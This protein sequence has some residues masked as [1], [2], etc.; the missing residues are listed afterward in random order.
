MIPEGSE[1]GVSGQHLTLDDLFRRAGVRQP[2]GLA[3]ADPPNRET[4][5]AGTPR[6]LSY[7]EA[8]R[9]ISAFAAR[10]RGLGL[11]TDTVIGLQLPNT[12]ESVIALLGI[13]R[14][15]MIAAPLPVL[16]HRREIVSA[17]GRAGA[18]AIVT[19]SR[20]GARRQADIAMQAAAE[21]FPIRY[22]CGFGEDLPDGM[23]PFDDIFA[24][25]PG[26]AVVPPVRAGQAA[27]HV[28]AVT[29]DVTR[30]GI[31][32]VMRSHNE[33]IAAGAA[34]S[35]EARMATDRAIVSTIPLCSFAGLAVTLVPWL[36]A[37][38]ALHLHH[39]FAPE[40]FSAQCDSLD[41][42]VVAL[43]GP[44]VAP[45]YE[46]GLLRAPVKTTIALWRAPE[47]IAAA[48]AWSGDGV[49]MD[50]MAGDETGLTAA[51]RDERE[52]TIANLGSPGGV[53]R[54]GGYRFGFA[55]LEALVATA[56]PNAT[57]VSLPD[58]LTGERLA[59]SSADP[60]ALRAALEESGIS[61]LI[62]DAFRRRNGMA[63]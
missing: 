45:L 53:A 52:A 63:A 14:A 59:G 38:G 40:T 28:A 31:V 22:V 2:E 6:R 29:F 15:D 8:D 37:G 43:P 41:A 27:A 20:I 42:A 9:A 19:A 23:V 16:W 26:S 55:D 44:V 1:S 18:K 12:V 24:T 10:L 58:V 13:L 5:T 54:V 32:P 7:V 11:A 36:E 50:V 57:I 60:E 62:Y 39:G 51:R 35:K 34:V 46:A 3:L 56:D 30:D 47:R 25:A 61:P 17:L 33:L 49:L 21:L 48:P 4:F